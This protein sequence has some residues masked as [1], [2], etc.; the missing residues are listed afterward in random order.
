[1]VTCVAA[2]E[3]LVAICVQAL[4]YAVCTAVMEF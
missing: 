4:V 2:V 3:V 1:V